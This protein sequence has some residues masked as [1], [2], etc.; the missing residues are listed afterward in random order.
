MR[1]SDHGTTFMSVEGDERE[2]RPWHGRTALRRGEG[3]GPLRVIHL[4][5]H[6]W[7]GGLVNWDSG[8]TSER[9]YSSSMV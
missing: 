8:R 9:T 3:G 1:S 4:S 7:P 5:R 6:K 2:L